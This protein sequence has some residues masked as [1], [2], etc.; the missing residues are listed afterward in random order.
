MIDR[1]I[2]I[3]AEHTSR[4]GPLGDVSRSVNRCYKVNLF[5]LKMWLGGAG[6]WRGVVRKRMSPLGDVITGVNRCYKVRSYVLWVMGYLIFFASTCWSRGT[7][8][9]LK[10]SF[11]RAEPA[12]WAM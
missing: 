7:I 9:A 6:R 8:L 3:H 2:D 5:S 11:T 10:T 12:R 4:A 1:H